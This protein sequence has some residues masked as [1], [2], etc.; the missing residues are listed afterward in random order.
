MS[1][2]SLTERDAVTLETQVHQALA[3]RKVN[4]INTRREFFYA[5]PGE[6]KQIL[7]QV[8]GAHLVEYR[9]EPDALEWHASGAI[10]RQT[11]GAAGASPMDVEA[12]A[13]EALEDATGDLAKAEGAEEDGGLNRDIH[14]EGLA[15]DDLVAAPADDGVDAEFEQQGSTEQQ[16]ASA[17]SVPGG[18]DGEATVESRIEQQDPTM[19]ASIVA[20]PPRGPE[21]EPTPRLEAELPPANW[22]PDPQHVKRLRY[23]DGRRWTEHIAD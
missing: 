21:Q 10:R 13:L 2:L 6:V 12:D 5:S 8:A 23:W 17:P 7:A 16:E 20:S 1:H 11:Q 15:D 9:E 14:K 22:Y 3:A 18:Q 4:R 19:S